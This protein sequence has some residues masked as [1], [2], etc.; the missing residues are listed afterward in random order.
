MPAQAAIIEE[1]DFQRRHIRVHLP[2]KVRI[3]G[4]TYPLKDLS[5]GG[6]AVTAKDFI[7]GDR[8][9]LPISLIFYFNDFSIHLD[10]ITDVRHYAPERHDL[11]LRF[12]ENENSHAPLL[13]TLIQ[14]FEKGNY[15]HSGDLL[16]TAWEGN[17]VHFPRQT[18]LENRKKSWPLW[19]KCFYLAL[20]LGLGFSALGFMAHNVY[21]AA[22][23]FTSHDAFVSS[24]S[25]EI[26]A[27]HE[28]LFKN[29]LK[30]DQRV[31]RQGEEIG[32]IIGPYSDIQSISSPCNCWIQEPLLQSGEKVTAGTRLT[33][34]IELKT[35]ARVQATILPQD[36]SKIKIGMAADVKIAGTSYRTNGRVSALSHKVEDGISRNVATLDLKTALPVSLNGFPAVVTF[37]TRGHP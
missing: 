32:Q 36:L 25:R 14:S 27:A 1:T 10:C 37:Y 18:Y 33:S 26:K 23:T 30:P 6:V 21:K 9:T 24:P 11:G 22:F 16:K 20:I 35:K 29:L 19:R 4:E 3:D 7:P 12:S 13:K 15:L 8:S 28:G 17:V 34:L 2:A 5:P 31:V